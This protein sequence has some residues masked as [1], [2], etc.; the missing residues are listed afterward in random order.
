MAKP[1][2]RRQTKP[3]NQLSLFLPSTQT[4][5]WSNLPEQTRAEI[6]RILAE[7]LLHV[8]RPRAALGEHGDD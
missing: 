3:C 5:L 6:V 4:A 1:K 2:C 7:L 8:R